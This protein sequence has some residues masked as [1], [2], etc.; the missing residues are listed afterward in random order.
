MGATESY[1]CLSAAYSENE[2][3]NIDEVAVSRIE[4]SLHTKNSPDFE[5]LKIDDFDSILDS[6][7]NKTK[8]TVITVHG[9]LNSR[10]SEIN[11][12]LKAGYSNYTDVNL[13]ILD[14][15]FMTKRICYSLSWRRAK[16]V[17]KHLAAF[18]DFLF[19]YDNFQW[20]NVVIV[21][22]SLDVS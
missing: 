15:S 2:E 13:I 9:F 5:I 16:A 12:A 8:P 21:G 3:S 14:W 7:F 18:M 17:G 19:G 20:S 1:A 4:F 10:E 11:V 6:K 22:E